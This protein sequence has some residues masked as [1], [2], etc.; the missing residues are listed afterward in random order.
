MEIALVGI[1]EGGLDAG[2]ALQRR[3]GHHINTPPTPES[4]GALDGKIDGIALAVGITG[5]AVHLVEEQVAHRG[6]A[7]ASG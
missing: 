2:M 3:G 4:G 5:I 7:Q 6:G 1:E